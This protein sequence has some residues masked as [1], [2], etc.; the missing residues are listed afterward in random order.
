[1]PGSRPFSTFLA[2]VPAAWLAAACL[3]V[4]P[5]ARAAGPASAS[6]SSPP[7]KSADAALVEMV[8]AERAFAILAD[9]R[10]MREAFITY[11]AEDGIGFD[12]G[13][14]PLR[15]TMRDR[16]AGPEGFK[17]LW[18]PRY[19]DVAASG[20]VGYL[21]GPYRVESVGKDGQPVTRHGCF[22][23]VWRRQPDGAWRNV[24]D[25]GV[26]LPEAPAFAEGFTRAPHEDRWAGPPASAPAK[27]DAQK[28]LKEAEQ[29]LNDA[30]RA[31]TLEEALGARLDPAARVHREGVAPADGAEAARRLLAGAGR[32]AVASSL[33]SRASTAGDLGW[34]YGRYAFAGAT[35]ERGSYAR[36]WTRDRSGAWRVA[37]DITSADREAR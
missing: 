6:P 3:L 17:L 34:T 19:G 29:T 37:A 12:N 10:G 28:T 11:I 31:T 36:V 18:E 23:S 27:D 22:F 16:P 5:A 1:M 24:L 7:P 25:L 20:E 13:P 21:T 15:Q 26:R 35:P 2:R 32:L 33:F 14:I 9:E 4:A 30:A 8:G